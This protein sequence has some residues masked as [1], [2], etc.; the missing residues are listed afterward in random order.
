MLPSGPATMTL[1][2][3][4]PEDKPYSLILPVTGEILPILFPLNSV[5]QR[6]PLGPTVML[7]ITSN[8]LERVL[9]P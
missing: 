4:L 1:G 3:D 6:L 9:P 8:N 2:I 5:N 7:R